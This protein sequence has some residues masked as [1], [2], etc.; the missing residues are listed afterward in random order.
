MDLNEMLEVV[1]NK[2]AK[3]NNKKFLASGIKN[4]R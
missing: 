1:N 4:W 3:G 2:E